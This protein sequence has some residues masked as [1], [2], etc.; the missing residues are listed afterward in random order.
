VIRSSD[1]ASERYVPRIQGIGLRVVPPGALPTRASPRRADALG[2]SVTEHSLPQPV[3]S[4]H[5][6]RRAADLQLRWYREF[7][8]KNH[9]EGN[10]I[11]LTAA[12]KL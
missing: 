1:R 6:L 12:L 8:G 10:T 4:E 2:E 7:D 11:Y 5:E 3:L 9:L